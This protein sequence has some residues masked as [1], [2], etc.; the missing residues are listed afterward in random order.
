VDLNLSGQ[1]GY[2]VLAVIHAA[3]PDVD[4]CSRSVFKVPGDSAIGV[5]SIMMLAEHCAQEINKYRLNEPSDDRYGLEIFR[6]A[7]TLRDNEA[8]A[9]LQRQFTEIVR[10]WFS[11]HLYRDTALRYESEQDYI[12]HAFQRLW[13]A[14]SNQGF[15]FTSLSGV[16]H[17]LRMCLHCAIMDTLR[18]YART[19]LEI[20]PEQGDADEPQ[21]EDQYNE[22]ELWETICSLLPNERER[23]V[24]YLHFRCNLKAREIMRY[25]P[26]EFASESEIY[27]LKRNVLE[28][29]MRNVDKVRWRLGG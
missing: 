18:M 7:I 28:R 29:V 15:T 27:R 2:D 14:V 16:L 9:S 8:W 11:Y 17:Y 3:S 25:C 12:D 4:G 1:D 23:R 19:C 26:G 5:M 22:G 6:R 10:C 20:L 24:A 13:Q 21:I